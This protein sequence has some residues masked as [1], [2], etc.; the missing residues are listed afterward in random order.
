MLAAARAFFRE[1]DVLEV[2]TPALAQNTVTDPNI[3]SLRIE[4]GGAAGGSFL[5]TSP[6]FAMKR[7]LAAGMPDI[8]Q[9]GPAFRGGEL[10]RRHQPEFC[11]LEWYRQG[12]SLAEM[13]AETCALINALGQ[14]AGLA[15]AAAA[16]DTIRYRDLFRSELGLDPL[17]AGP[18]ELASAARR[19]EA[20]E[21]DRSLA[22]ELDRQPEAA[23][24]LLLS[25]HLV[26]GL[27]RDRLTVISHF[28]A[29]QAALARLDPEDPD[30]AERFEVFF[31]GL[32]LANGYRECTDASELAA[33]FERDR[34]RR[35]AVG[36]PDR[37]P[38]TAL[39][40]AV[41]AGL[42]E[43]SG[44]AVGFD[45]VLMAWLEAEDIREVRPFAYAMPGAT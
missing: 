38:D 5:Q 10:G 24:D 42:P 16:A 35:R 1:R 28:P 43:C 12:F 23:L 20:G 7:L 3:H 44:V 17:A 13:S 25:R 39:L 19:L 18:A 4:P 26:P 14:A 31:R 27:P 45:R 37:R 36:L 33:R 32:E 2:D 30:C 6:E 40:A 8:Y 9:L 29:S 22:D 11:L 15:P 41:A 34:A 21:L